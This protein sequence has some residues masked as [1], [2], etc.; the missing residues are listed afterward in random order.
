MKIYKAQVDGSAEPLEVN[1]LFAVQETITASKTLKAVE[2]G[3]TINVGTDALVVTLPAINASNIGMQFVVRNI[4]ANGNNIITISPA[5]TDAVHGKIANAAADSVASGVVD[6][7]F[8]NT[9]ATAK[10]GDFVTL[11]AVSLTEWYIT[12]GAGIWES[13]A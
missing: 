11:E 2:S 8:V 12:G 10:K 9:K 5:A 7:N 6:K 13:Q 3:K 1:G 4:G